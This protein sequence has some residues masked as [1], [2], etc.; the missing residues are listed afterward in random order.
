[1]KYIPRGDLVLIK[2]ENPGKVRGLHM[3][4][5]AAEGKR[6]VIVALGPEVKEGTLKVGDVVYAVGTPGED[7]VRIPGESSL[8]LTKQANIFCTVEQ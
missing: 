3:P 1:M 7:L 4:D 6:L 2:Q 5:V 8:F